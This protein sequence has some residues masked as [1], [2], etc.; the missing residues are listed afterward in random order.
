MEIWKYLIILSAI[1][2]VILIGNKV[3]YKNDYNVIQGQ[4]DLSDG[5]GSAIISYPSGYNYQNCVAIAVGIDMFTGEGIYSYFGFNTSKS[6]YEV[7]FTAT[8]IRLLC[9][10]TENVGVTGT[11]NYKILLMKI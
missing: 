7:R 6:S 3:L 9:F 8:D 10:S 1:I 11:K 5:S 2:L 4:I